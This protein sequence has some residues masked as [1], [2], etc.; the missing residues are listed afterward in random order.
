MQLL[1]ID[2]HQH[3]LQAESFTQCTVLW[4]CLLLVALRVTCSQ[5]PCLSY[6][7]DL[8]TTILQNHVLHFLAHFLWRCF[9]WPT[10]TW[11]VF[12]RFPTPIKLL[13]P[14]LYL[15]VGRW[16]IAILSWTSI[17][18]FPSF[19]RN[20]ITKWSLKSLMFI[21][22]PHAI[23]LPILPLP[24]LNV[25]TD[26]WIWLLHVKTCPNLHVQGHV[27]CSDVRYWGR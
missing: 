20:L 7:T 9:H 19:V 12:N 11:I 8:N 10:W 26:L 13:G 17:G 25:K 6:N 4:F 16:N 2:T 14:K 21:V 18:F 24:A 3:W 27:W 23:A 5:W 1:S 15:I 22:D